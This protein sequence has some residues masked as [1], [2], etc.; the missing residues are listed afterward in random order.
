MAEAK[1]S[2]LPFTISLL[3]P[4]KGVEYVSKRSSLLCEHNYLLRI[5]EEN[6][7][8]HRRGLLGEEEL[9]VPKHLVLSKI[10]KGKQQK[11]KSSMFSQSTL[12]PKHWWR[13]IKTAVG[14][15]H[16]KQVTARNQ[17]LGEKANSWFH[18]YVFYITS[19]S[20]GDTLEQNKGT[21]HVN[22]RIL[23]ST[24]C[25]PKLIQTP[26][27]WRVFS[28]SEKEKFCPMI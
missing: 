1:K 9:L 19:G 22:D 11:P 14:Y 25:L 15:C 10:L 3:S 2:L 18:I 26:F 20:E 21:A 23:P 17:H 7:T 5:Q 8:A 6:R 4:R 13:I 28:F 27:F 12:R 24:R 16:S